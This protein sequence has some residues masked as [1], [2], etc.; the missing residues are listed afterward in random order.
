MISIGLEPIESAAS[1]R[2]L[3]VSASALSTWREKKGTV[4][5]TSGTIAPGTSI[6]VP[7]IARES[8]ITHVSR[9]M[10]GIER[11]KLITLSST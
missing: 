6:A 1:T 8:G 2:P 9:M 10:K 4:P 11:K 7:M 3:S 5:S